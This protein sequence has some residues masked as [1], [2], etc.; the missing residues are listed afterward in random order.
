MKRGFKE[1]TGAEIIHAYG[2]TE[3]TPLVAV[4]YR[5]KPAVA[6]RLSPDE[7]WDPKRR[8]GLLVT[9]VDVRVLGEDDRDVP[10]DGASVGEVCMRGPWIAGRY[11]NAPGTEA[12]FAGGYWRSGD[13]GTIDEDGYLK[14]VDRI[15]DVIK[16]GGEWISSIDVENTLAGHPEILDAAVVGLPH[17]KWQER[18]LALV[19]AKRE[20]RVT[21]DELRE[22]LL[23][24]FARWQLPDQIHFVAEIPKTSVGKTS[25]KT[26]VADYHDLYTKAIGNG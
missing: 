2:A 22:A 20:A 1:L 10:H 3:T 26:I 19:I 9:G 4:N 11:H 5:L 8:Q 16:S 7:Q 18:P 12:N 13:A 14:V 6:A 23:A 15:K 25:K 24:R 21:E 17:E